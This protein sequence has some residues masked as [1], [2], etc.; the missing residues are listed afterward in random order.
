MPTS[1]IVSASPR[2]VDRRFHACPSACHSAMANDPHQRVVRR[3]GRAGGVNS[4][5][6]SSPAI[7]GGPGVVLVDHHHRHH[8]GSPSVT[9]VGCGSGPPRPRRPPSSRPQAARGCPPHQWTMIHPAWHS[10]PSPIQGDRHCVFDTV[11]VVIAHGDGDVLRPVAH[12]KREGVIRQTAMLA[13][14][15]GASS[16]TDSIRGTV[17][18]CRVRGDG[19]RD[20][21]ATL[22]RI[23]IRGQVVFLGPRRP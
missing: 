12:V 16:C 20:V 11:P 9:D 1:G 14:V 15:R 4:T 22:H 13:R 21:S 17:E 23:V 8:D 19:H 18:M 10:P 5:L 3:I 2:G 7:N 6:R